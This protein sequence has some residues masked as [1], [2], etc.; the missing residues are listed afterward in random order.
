MDFAVVKGKACFA[1]MTHEQYDSGK[2]SL[3]FNSDKLYTYTCEKNGKEYRLVFTSETTYY[4][5]D[6]T[7][8]TATLRVNDEENPTTEIKVAD[9]PINYVNKD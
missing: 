3:K 8:N 4:F 5:S 6:I 2:Y 7:A 9:P 1:T